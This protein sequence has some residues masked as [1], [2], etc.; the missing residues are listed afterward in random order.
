[1][2]ADF[3]VIDNYISPVLFLS[4]LWILQ[5]MVST[6]E[7]LYIFWVHIKET[8]QIFAESVDVHAAPFF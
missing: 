5:T 2:N 3:I 1:M 4:W 8:Y 6:E 7:L